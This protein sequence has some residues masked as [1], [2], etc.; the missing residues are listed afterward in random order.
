MV[1]STHVIDNQRIK[2]FEYLKQRLKDSDAFYFV[3]A[4]FSIYG[5]ELLEDE[6]NRMGNVRFLFGD[7]TSVEDLDPGKKDPKSFTLTE[8]GLVPNHT[9]HQKYLAKRCAKWVSRDDVS[10]RSISQSNFLHGKMYLANAAGETGSAVV[11]S[12]NFTKSGLGGSNRSNLE[13]NV[14]TTDGATLTQLQEWYDLLWSNQQRTED[15]K[16]KVLDALARIGKDHAPELVYYKTLYELFRKEIEARL[17]GD[18]GLVS[19]GFYDSQVWNALYEFQKDGAKGV[20]AR[21]RQHNGCILADS[22]GLGK[23]YT[24]LAVIKF[25][26]QRNERVLVLCPRKLYENWSLYLDNN[27][28]IQNPF[29]QDRFNYTLLA[30]TDLS[31]DSGRSGSVDLANFNWRNYDLVVIDE[32]HNFRNSDGQRYQKLLK[33]IIAAGVKTKVLM[34]SATPVNTSLI[35]LRNQIH[36][37]T[38]GR[39]DAFRESLDVGNIGSLMSAAQRQFKEWESDKSRKGRRDKGALLEKLGAEFFRLLGGVSIARSR[40]HIEQSYD[41]EMERIG[42]FPVHAAPVNSYP[43]T[44]LNGSLSYKELAEGI[45]KFKLAVYQP[46]TYVTDPGRLSDL[47]RTRKAQNF[48]QADSER[49]L[50]GMMRTNFLK[51]LESSAHS[52]TLTLGRTIGKID[53]LVEKI[54]RYQDREPSRG[55]L[56]EADVLP[57]DDEE[58]FV[59]RGR[60]PYRLGELDLS[61]WLA[62]LK[63]DKTT[64]GAVLERVAAITPE[65]DGKLREIKQ[66]IRD[67]AANPPTNNDGQPNRKLL[68]FTTFKD[69]ALYLYHNLT[70]LATE[71]DINMA[72]VTGDETHTTVGTNTFNAILTNFAPVAR[73]RGET[74]SPEID[75]LIATDCISEGQNLQD[76]DTVLNYDIHWNPVRLIQRFGRIDRIGSR[77]PAVYMQNYWPTEDMDVYLKLESRVQARMVLADIAASGNEDPFTS[78]DA[79]TELRFRDEQLLKLQE[80][81]LDMD[82]LNDTPVMSDFTLD[83]FLAQLLRY[84]ER[85]KDELEALPYGV[86]A[87]AEDKADAAQQGVIFFLRQINTGAAS[88][89]RQVAS[90]V[91][92]YYL[93]YIQDNGTIRYGCVQAGQALGVFEAAAAGKTEPIT[94]LCDRFDRSTNLG[95]DMGQYDKLLT[96]AIAHIGQ[97]H[98]TAQNRNLKPGGSP[99]FQFSPASETPRTAADFELITWLVL[100]SPNGESSPR[101]F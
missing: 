44:D 3:S 70:D 11:G 33:D 8:D 91:H 39:D 98:S 51:R 40:R 56:A 9:L 30:H 82:D 65:R 62:D 17:A 49:F 16:Q 88:S 63:Q 13:I 37:M 12:S 52:L 95:K 15:V 35:D 77:N 83:Q 22:V 61:T 46:T 76:C 89:R 58:F 14:T 94:Q 1:S 6:L 4:Y 28:H 36:L 73:N 68:V 71:L 100:M 7:P 74:A 81:I 92:P 53:S 43:P 23:T 90:P 18:D 54:E 2:V 78:D 31:R 48:N 27:S 5:Y 69:T 26:E 34:L 57:E 50:V 10:I 86:Y 45:E 25:F 66:A 93:V 55:D 41:A 60:H 42:R 59:N 29:P 87:V 67:K 99:D 19:S 75:L 21:L 96:D 85:N 97:A 64:L 24:A 84:L 32:S 80:E 47:E 79:Q 38:E 72:M 20:I 101:L